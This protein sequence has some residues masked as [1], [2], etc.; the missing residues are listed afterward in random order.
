MRS[1]GLTGSGRR[2]SLHFGQQRLAIDQFDDFGRP[3]PAGTNAASLSFQHFALVVDDIAEPI[4]SAECQGD[5]GGWAAASA[6]SSGGVFAF[7]FAIPTVIRWSFCNTGPAPGR[8]GLALT[9]RPSA[10]PIQR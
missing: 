10:W 8:G 6:A 9:T 5:F 7:K 4:I 3:Y 2:Q 1:L